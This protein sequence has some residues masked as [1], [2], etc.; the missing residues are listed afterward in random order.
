MVAPDLR[1]AVEAKD[2]KPCRVVVLGCGLGVNSIYL[3]QEGFDVT[4]IDVAPT[5]LDKAESNA[6]EAG[7]KIRWLLANVLT[8]PE[9]E[10]FDLIFDRGCYHYVRYD[11]AKGFIESLD[12]LSRPGTK[13]FV[14]SCN[15]DSAPGV[16]ESTM[17]EDFSELFDF[18]WVRNSTIFTGKEGKGRLP[19]W[20]V[21]LRRKEKV[22]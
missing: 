15:R 18:E 16:R 12:R 6:K 19:S 7:V 4:A 1:K 10:P 20:S 5:A 2:I 3:A 21:M 13:F 14:L 9:L 22:T 17:R 11:D 8:L